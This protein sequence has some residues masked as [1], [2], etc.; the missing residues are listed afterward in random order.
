MLD[1]DVVR[2]WGKL[3]IVGFGGLLWR[4]PSW[5]ALGQQTSASN[6]CLRP[7]RLIATTASDNVSS[8][9][10]SPTSCQASA[11]TSFSLPLHD[12]QPHIVA[13]ISPC[14]VK[15]TSMNARSRKKMA[16]SDLRGSRYLVT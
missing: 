14:D 5:W 11:D 15:Y 6:A 1:V 3:M 2:F 9:Y 16:L 8:T 10:A 13:T 12:L 7:T 4:E